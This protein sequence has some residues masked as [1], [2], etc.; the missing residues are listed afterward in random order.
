MAIAQGEAPRG[1]VAP[2]R[3]T[4]RMPGAL[5]GRQER[6]RPVMEEDTRGEG[7]I[8]A[9]DALAGSRATRLRT[10]GAGRH[11]EPQAPQEIPRNPYTASTQKRAKRKS[12]GRPRRRR[13]AQ[14]NHQPRYGAGNRHHEDRSAPARA[15]LLGRHAANT[16]PS[17]GKG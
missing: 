14:A 4:A 15:R 5:G 13:K 8:G 6:S 11:S 12:Q 1:R 3:M 9:L 17:P 7:G 10:K 2:A 16:G